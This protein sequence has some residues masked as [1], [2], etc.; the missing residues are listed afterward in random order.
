MLFCGLTCEGRGGDPRGLLPGGLPRLLHAMRML[1]QYNLPLYAVAG[2]WGF[3]Q[4][5]TPPPK[6]AISLPRGF[7]TGRVSKPPPEPR[8][9]PFDPVDVIKIIFHRVAGFEGLCTYR[10][11]SGQTLTLSTP[12]RGRAPEYPTAAQRSPFAPAPTWRI[13]QG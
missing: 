8:R 4:W 6:G 1:H 10:R 12:Q 9:R 5:R 3:G 2:G 7:R 13:A 11:I